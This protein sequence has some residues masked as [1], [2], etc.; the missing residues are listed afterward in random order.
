MLLTSVRVSQA[1]REQGLRALLL[2]QIA[3]IVGGGEARRQAALFIL[4]AKETLMVNP[5]HGSSAGRLLVYISLILLRAVSARLSSIRAHNVGSLRILAE[6]RSRE[7]I[8]EAVTS[9]P[10]IDRCRLAADDFNFVFRDREP[11]LDRPPTV[12]ADTLH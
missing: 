3:V 10:K 4:V 6:I 11:R 8:A 2:L 12:A 7:E 9:R 5:W 1:L